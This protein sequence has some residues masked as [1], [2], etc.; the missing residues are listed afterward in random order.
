M[1]WKD[2][3]VDNKIFHTRFGDQYNL[4][5]WEE[6]KIFFLLENKKRKNQAINN[7]SI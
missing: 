5:P 4:Y 6:L 7:N 1:E 3:P 2:L